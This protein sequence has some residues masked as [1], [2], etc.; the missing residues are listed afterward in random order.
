MVE[1]QSEYLGLVAVMVQQSE[2]VGLR[3]KRV[4]AAHARATTQ[5]TPQQQILPLSELRASSAVENSASL[6]RFPEEF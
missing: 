2:S 6:N 4:A 5:R 1:Q 3:H